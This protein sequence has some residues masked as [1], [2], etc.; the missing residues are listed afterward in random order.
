MSL[1]RVLALVAIAPFVLSAETR[2]QCPRWQGDFHLPGLDGNAR[3]LLA[4]DD[5]SGRKLYVGGDFRSAGRLPADYLVR[6]TGVAWESFGGSALDYYVEDMAEFDDGSGTA[7]YVAG[8]FSGIGISRIARWDGAA[9]SDVGGGMNGIVRALAV[10]D[11]GAGPALYA[12]GAFSSAGGNPAN[13]IARWD[14]TAWTP[15]GSGLVYNNVSCLT[16]FD[17]GSGPALYA[18]GSFHTA[19][20]VTAANV[21]RWRNGAWSAA[22]TLNSHVK[23]LC[24]YDDGNGPKLYAGVTFGSGI[25]RLENGVWSSV[26]GGMA[27]FPAPIGVTAL[28]TFDDGSGSKLYASGRF[29]TAGGSPARNV[30]RWDGNVWEQLADGADAGDG[31]STVVEYAFGTFDDGLG[32]G[33]SL[34]VGVGAHGAVS[35]C[36]IS[37]WTGSRLAPLSGGA[38]P[39]ATRG[40]TYVG[41]VVT[42][43]DGSGEGEELYV[44]GGFDYV[45]GVNSPHFARWNGW[46]WR[47]FGA[48]PELGD[49]QPHKLLVHD[50]G[51]GRALHAVGLFPIA[52]VP[53]LRVVRWSQSQ[54]S[55][56]HSVG[57]A[58]T[59]G[60]DVLALSSVDLGGGADLYVAGTF[61]SVDGVSA[62]NIARYSGG[63]WSALGSGLSGQFS[64]GRA[65][66]RFDDGGGPALY[67]GGN[68][69]RAGDTI[70]NSIA[71]WQNGGWSAL[72]AGVQTATGARGTVDSF[73]TFD[74]GSGPALYVTGVFAQAGGVPATNVARWKNG[75]WSAVG[76]GIPTTYPIK[77]HVHDDGTGS[78]LYA[79][80]SFTSAGGAPIRYLARWDGQ[81]W[82]SVGSGVDGPT[83]LLASYAGALY[84]VGGQREAG[85]RASFLMARWAT[86]DFQDC[87]SD[88]VDDAC[89][90]EVGTEIDVDRDGVPD[91]CQPSGAET[92][93]AGDGSSVPCPCG[94]LAARGHGCPSSLFPGGAVLEAFG[95]SSVGADTLRLVGSAM[96]N[97]AVLYVQGTQRVLGAAGAGSVLGDGLRCAGGTVVRLGTKSNV[98]NGSRYPATGDA[99]ISVRG[100]IAPGGGRRVYQAWYRNAAIGFCTPATSNLTNAIGVDWTP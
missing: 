50:D 30:A 78:A 89:E 1:C 62:A 64:V 87:D 77:L 100:G 69:F 52:G 8:G 36:G 60:D 9:W 54:W 73:A 58:G 85:G 23:A 82:S 83:G 49:C 81:A 51:T 28:T 35:S 16:V 39:Y 21:A 32:G 12:A 42:F 59:F 2:A 5:G 96:P 15:L 10:F 13:A 71:R 98:G 72:G 19:G 61:D 57:F 97:S 48:I 91:A 67:V 88:G 31:N 74:D 41:D 17:D 38:A 29:H 55:P 79:A 65:M 34:Y 24:A 11:D 99:A 66:T 93:C 76:A 26:G 18:G 80:G 68:F 27:A 53:T 33:E 45:G 90:I 20:G 84:L 25:F 6:W 14:G 43:D 75:A 86:A 92:I 95:T 4:H 3:A 94:D 46:R 56:L 37:R 7:L 70:V 63:A 40:N 44:A 47:E 22:G